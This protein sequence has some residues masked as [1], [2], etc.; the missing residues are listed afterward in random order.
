MKFLID[1]NL[2]PEWVSVF[3]KEGH[4]AIHWSSVGKMDATDREIMNYALHNG[5]IVFTHDLDFGDIL[6]A[7]GGE[8]PSVIQARTNDTTPVILGRFLFKAIEQFSKKLEKGALIT[9][10]PGK[11][12]ARILPLKK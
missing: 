8:G 5:W 2:T 10:T 9:I 12:R 7:T 4:Q 11:M 1:M 3:Q 6:A